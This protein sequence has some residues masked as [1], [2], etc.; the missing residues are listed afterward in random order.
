MVP[1]L[2]GPFGD[3]NASPAILEVLLRHGADPN[4]R[5]EDMVLLQE[6]DERPDPM[7]YPTGSGA[8]KTRWV[9]A[10]ADQ[11]PQCRAQSALSI[12]LKRDDGEA[13]ALFA[14]N[15]ADVATLAARAPDL[16]PETAEK[17]LPVLLP[18]LDPCTK[19]ELLVACAGADDAARARLLLEAGA[20]A[21][22]TGVVPGSDAPMSPLLHAILRVRKETV[23]LL[24]YRGAVAR[25]PLEALALACSADDAAAAAA[26]LDEGADPNAACHG[27]TPLAVATASCS[28]RCVELLLG[29]GADPD[30][31]SRLWRG[32]RDIWSAAAMVSVDAKEGEAVVPVLL[33]LMIGAL[34]IALVLL[35]RGADRAVVWRGATPLGHC[36]VQSLQEAKSMWA[37]GLDWQ[38]A[39]LAKTVEK[40][41]KRIG[42][43]NEALRTARGEG[44]VAPEEEEEVR[45]EVRRLE[46]RLR[47]ASAELQTARAVKDQQTAVLDA[48][49]DGA[50]I[51]LTD[52]GP[53]GQ[54][55][56]Y[57]ALHLPPVLQKLL[58]HRVD[59]NQASPE[60]CSTPLIYAIGQKLDN[61]VAL[62]LQHAA[63]PNLAALGGDRRGL[64][65]LMQAASNAT[66]AGALLT[67][68]ARVDA[69]DADGLPALMYAIRA[70]NVDLTR[71]LLEH[72]ADISLV[73]NNGMTAV[74]MTNSLQDYGPSK[75]LIKDLLTEN[76]GVAW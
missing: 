41:P 22:C 9:R 42:R 31:A 28:P 39:D 49:L 32:S 29:R 63:D 40:V 8:V 11:E 48:L 59:V 50:Q 46:E 37:G 44:T 65:P 55:L 76:R 52:K 70:Q 27:C 12:A 25:T 35:R 58:D 20:E 4:L 38:V 26:A 19:N 47:E 7:M 74:A 72:G 73:S 64:T 23:Q 43:L 75:S 34:D 1:F 57:M 2:G 10:A 24:R 3:S 14:A 62:L 53:D 69:V 17:V 30:R 66:H 36:L 33:A 54:P 61:A 60:D 45:A 13:L 51:R 5:T 68:G 6:P 67:N 21:Q 18:L 71:V 16:R 15:G 56:L